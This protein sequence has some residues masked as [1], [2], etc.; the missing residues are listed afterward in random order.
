M[1]AQAT[2]FTFQDPSG[3]PIAGGTLTIRLNT[4]AVALGGDLQIAANRLTTVTLDSTGSA[5]VD[6]WPNAQLSPPG[7]VYLIQVYTVEGQ[8][9]WN[10]QMTV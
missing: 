4:D 6:L 5:T 7:S 10:E 1:A 8:L 3:Q 9:V 2:T